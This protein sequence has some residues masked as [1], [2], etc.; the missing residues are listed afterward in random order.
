MN[1]IQFFI[2]T[3]LSSLL[4]LLI[5]GQ[6]LLG[7]SVNKVQT[8]IALAQQLANQGNVAQNGL[9]ALARRILADT[10]RTNDPGLKALVQ[11]YQIQVSGG[12]TTNTTE[13]PATPP[14]APP[15]TH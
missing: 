6:L 8:Q 4:F 12:G 9:N 5:I 3:G 7:H 14:A 1:R 13:T 10:Q 15:A 11:K 2:L